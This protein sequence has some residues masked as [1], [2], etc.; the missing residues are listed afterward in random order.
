M[1]VREYLAT[2]E[3]GFARLALADNYAQRRLDWENTMWREHEWIWNMARRATIASDVAQIAR[4]GDAIAPLPFEHLIS[5]MEE[6]SRGLQKLSEDLTRSA[7]TN[8]ALESMKVGEVH[9]KLIEPIPALKT[10]LQPPIEPFFSTVF[11]SARAV[12]PLV[13]LQ[14]RIG[15][16]TSNSV[17]QAAQIGSTI[18]D[19]FK[20]ISRVV[21]LARSAYVENP[22]FGTESVVGRFFDLNEVVEHAARTYAIPDSR[23][24]MRDIQ[25]EIQG[26]RAD[27]AS[28]AKEERRA[29]AEQVAYE[30]RW[31]RCTLWL[32]TLSIVV[33][34]Y[35]VYEAQK[36]EKHEE[37]PPAKQQQSSPPPVKL[38]SDDVG[39][40][41]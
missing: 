23:S 8:A 24:E 17:S 35:G 26:L 21:E 31:N 22:L 28:T 38:D 16:L 15:M 27:Q 41:P 25:R 32:M 7:I 9:R 12:K 19:A 37:T 10:V 34:V 40:C 33:Q 30:R 13:E 18:A 39:P 4:I 1:N 5:K 3:S 14:Q 29:R 20:D 11:E 6:Q 36:P 2:Q